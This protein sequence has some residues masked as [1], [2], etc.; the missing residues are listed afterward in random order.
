MQKF[1]SVEKLVNQ[2]RPDK[3]VYC[4]RKNS[5]LSA[6]NYFQKKFPGKILYAVKT[7]P[8]EEV[9]KTLIKS[10]IDQFDVASI[11][12]IKAVRKFSQTAKCSYMHTVKSRESIKEAYLKYGIKTFALDTKDELIKIIESTNNAK[13]LELFV[14]VAVSNEHAEIDLS[15]KFGALSSEASGLLRLVK[16]N[17]NKIGLSF[18]VGSQCMHPISYTKGIAE[19]GNIIKKT[20]IIPNYINVGGGFPTIYP[21]LIA[22][23]S[24]NIQDD[25]CLI[26][27]H[28]EQRL[29][30]AS[31]CSPSYWDVRTKIGKPLKEIHDPVTTLEE[32]IGDRIST[33][34]RQSPLM[35][36]FARQNWLIHGDT[37]RFH[38]EEEKLLMSD[39]ST[40]FIRSEKETL[41]RF[42][43]DYSLFTINVL[44]EPLN[45]IFNYPEIQKGLIRSIKSFDE[46]EAIYF[47]GTDKINTLLEYLKA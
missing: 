2:L 30:A 15:K 22:E 24:L 5:I 46:D 10:G 29:L 11:E 20:K 37:K 13:D 27:S 39:P 45:K 25:L 40:W 42:H 7:N 43:E 19:I 44:F 28:G 3:P 35:K 32:K 14:R 47:G 38:L 6:S 9:I 1:K 36:P 18:H 41:C 31:I 16:Q 23:M 4:I 12:E 21:D 17:S 34:I 26:E 33:F 8:H